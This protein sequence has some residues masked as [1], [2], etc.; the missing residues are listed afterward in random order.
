MS[1]QQ[2]KEI[3][4]P[5]PGYEGIYDISDMGNVYSYKNKKHDG[6]IITGG[7]DSKWYRTISLYKNGSIKSHG[8]HRLVMLVFVGESELDVDHING[9]RADNR[10][11]NLRYC[12][13][14]QNQM[15]RISRYGSS[16]YKGVCWCKD[17]G[18]WRCVVRKNGK[19]FN[20]GYFKNE[21]D[22]AFAYDL[23]AKELFGEFSRLNF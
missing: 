6:K 8:L 19:R 11:E 20:L 22:A 2:P 3:W 23:K 5:I 10:L 13:R 7:I 9:D 4:K 18:K 17:M 21:K 16:K 14:S 1:I 12:T 15:N